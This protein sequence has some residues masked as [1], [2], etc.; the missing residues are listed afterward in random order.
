[1]RIPDGRLY[2]YRE[3]IAPT[4]ERGNTMQQ[5]T[6]LRSSARTTSLRS[7]VAAI[8]ALTL[9]VMVAIL[10]L[11]TRAPH[12]A[13]LAAVVVNPAHNRLFDSEKMY[14]PSASEYVSLG[15]TYAG[16][17]VIGKHAVQQPIY[18]SRLLADEAATLPAAGDYANGAW[19]EDYRVAPVALAPATT[20][21]RHVGSRTF[22]DEAAFVP[23]ADAYATLRA[24]GDYLPLAERTAGTPARAPVPRTFADQRLDVVTAAEYAALPIADEYF[25]DGTPR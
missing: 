19:G 5:S 6:A 9:L 3:L 13:P 12:S 25:R 17:A 8:L 10:G 7:I 4:Q 1:M 20:E 2:L 16:A 21:A 23:T 22:A 18:G 15:E 14:V 24:G 11:S